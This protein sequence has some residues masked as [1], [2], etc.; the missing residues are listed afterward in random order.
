MGRQS[1]LFKRRL[2]EQAEVGKKIKTSSPSDSTTKR[3][4][5][6]SSSSSQINLDRLD[7]NVST[8]IKSILEADQVSRA[9]CFTQKQ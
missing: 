6:N 4:G 2:R 9:F 5:D 3:D 7:P 8:L 1:N